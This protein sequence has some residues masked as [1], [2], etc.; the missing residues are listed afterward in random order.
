MSLIGRRLVLGQ[1]VKQPAINQSLVESGSFCKFKVR[2]LKGAESVH[3]ALVA[4]I[5]GNLSQ[6]LSTGNLSIMRVRHIVNAQ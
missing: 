4:K 6:N 3:A 1:P 5:P 2:S